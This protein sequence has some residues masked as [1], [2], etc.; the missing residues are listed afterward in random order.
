MRRILTALILAT[1]CGCWTP[2]SVTEVLP[3]H[4]EKFPAGSSF[5]VVKTERRV[6]AA[7]KRALRARGFEVKE[8]KDDAGL[9]MTAKVLG[10]EYNDAGFSGF[11]PR[12]DMELVITVADRK[13]KLV[14]ARSNVSVRSDLRIL[15]KYVKTL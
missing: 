6:E 12:D 11:H 14:R 1:L 13:T 4:T 3:K 7:L 5:F 10:W 2:G 15:E 8:K 9:V